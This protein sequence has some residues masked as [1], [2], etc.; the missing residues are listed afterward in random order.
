MHTGR[1]NFGTQ[2]TC[3]CRDMFRCAVPDLYP[4]THLRSKRRAALFQPN[5]T[6]IAMEIRAITFTATVAAA[7]VAQEDPRVSDHG[8][9]PTPARGAPSGEGWNRRCPRRWEGVGAQRTARARG[10]IH[11][12]T[13]ADEQRR[14]RERHDVRGHG[15][16]K[17]GVRRWWRFDAGGGGG[18]GQCYDRQGWRRRR[19]Q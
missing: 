15:S 12:P 8:S 5:P 11:A 3:V 16:A 10:D 7:L 1:C 13:S 4:I 2:Y 19:S 9:R 6:S 17:K 14:H 18:S